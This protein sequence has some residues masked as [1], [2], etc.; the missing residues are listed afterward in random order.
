MDGFTE[1][2]HRFRGDRPR[3]HPRLFSAAKLMRSLSITTPAAFFSSL[4]LLPLSAFAAV[5]RREFP[6][7]SCDHE[8]GGGEMNQQTCGNCFDRLAGFSTCI[9][10]A[11]EPEALHFQ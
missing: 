9:Q 5:S 2:S 10:A 3:P 4:I 6:R 1:R 8:N 11:A 7:P